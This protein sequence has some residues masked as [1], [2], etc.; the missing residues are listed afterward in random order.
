M[1]H[2]VHFTFK[3]SDDVEHAIGMLYSVAR[4]HPR[5]ILE[6]DDNV[7]VV[8]LN[9]TTIGEAKRD[10]DLLSSML[11]PLYHNIMVD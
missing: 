1:A 4:V 11:M 10:A 3:H 2:K 6:T 8:T 9:V 7:V 5:D